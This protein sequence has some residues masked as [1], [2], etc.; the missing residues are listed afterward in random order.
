MLPLSSRAG[1]FFS[2]DA[3]PFTCLFTSV[4][5]PIE[6]IAADK[7]FIDCHYIVDEPGEVVPSFKIHPTQLVAH[8][9]IRGYLCFYD[10]AGNVIHTWH[11]GMF[12]KASAMPQYNKTDAYGHP[13]FSLPDAAQVR[14]FSLPTGAEFN[15]VESNPQPSKRN[16]CEPIKIKPLCRTLRA[17]SPFPAPL[18]RYLVGI[19]TE[20]YPT[21]K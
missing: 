11:L 6:P 15:R 1:S 2:D 13:Y 12:S 17:F 21:G 16:P 5:R 3:L 7:T 20:R 14:L 8:G 19:H 10:A 4:A 18:P 9:A